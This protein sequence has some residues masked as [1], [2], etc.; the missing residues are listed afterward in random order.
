MK[1]LEIITELTTILDKKSRK[2]LEPIATVILKMREQIT[3]L[4]IS[5]WSE[6]YSYKNSREIF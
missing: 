3:M 1:K 2:Q 4:G 6:E 5:R